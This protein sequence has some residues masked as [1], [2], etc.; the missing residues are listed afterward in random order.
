M[1]YRVVIEQDED[2]LKTCS[3]CVSSSITLPSRSSHLFLFRQPA[4][5][6]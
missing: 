3:I 1:K 4:F 5:F 2:G 6:L